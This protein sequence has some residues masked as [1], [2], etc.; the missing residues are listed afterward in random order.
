[1]IFEDEN[2]PA[3]NGESQQVQR[4]YS[5][6]NT[7]LHRYFTDNYKYQKLLQDSFYRIAYKYIKATLAQN[8]YK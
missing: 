4:A 6:F 3:E 8:I 7:V 1:M 2:K 5:W